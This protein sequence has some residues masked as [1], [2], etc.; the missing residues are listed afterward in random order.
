MA[1]LSIYITHINFFNPFILVNNFKH[2]P[3]T[4]VDIDPQTSLVERNMQEVLGTE[5]QFES[6]LV[7]RIYV[8]PVSSEGPPHLIASY[9]SQ[10]DTEELFLPGSSPLPLTTRKGMLR[11]YLS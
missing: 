11:T 1:N 10:G 3:D 6:R 2:Q 4:S 5:V 8:F 9:D 7:G